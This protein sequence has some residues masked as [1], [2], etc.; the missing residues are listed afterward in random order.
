MDVET[1][2]L[3]LHLLLRRVREGQVFHA[4]LLPR[5]PP[6][7]RVWLWDLRLPSAPA[8]LRQCCALAEYPRL[9][10]P[11]RQGVEKP[12]L[13]EV[14]QRILLDGRSLVE[15]RDRDERPLV[16]PGDDGG[17]RPLREPLA[18]AQSCAESRA[19][20]L[21]GEALGRE[22]NVRREHPKSD[23]ARLVQEHPRAVEAHRL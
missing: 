20:F 11:S 2:N 12:S 4:P 19:I 18:I 17:D 6:A 23:P 3:P 9:F 15:I 21:D 16:P 8:L 7:R 10:G 22:V 13:D 5:G 14:L 1:E